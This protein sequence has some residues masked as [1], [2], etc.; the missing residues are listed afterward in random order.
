MASPPLT[1]SSTRAWLPPWAPRPYDH[2]LPV[3]EETYGDD[4]T[5]W[6]VNGLKEGDAD[7][8]L[9]DGW[10]VV[11]LWKRHGKAD[12]FARGVGYIKEAQRQGHPG[13]LCCL[14]SIEEHGLGGLKKHQ[15]GDRAV[16][17]RIR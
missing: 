16:P 17:A 8:L 1:C 12:H 6:C 15:E 13:A 2:N 7:T 4:F 11:S 3:A 9:Y 14:A 10:E 5:K